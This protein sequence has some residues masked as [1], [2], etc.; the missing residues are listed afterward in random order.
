[1]TA[2]KFLKWEGRQKSSTIKISKP[3]TWDWGR[4][5]GLSTSPSYIYTPLFTLTKKEKACSEAYVAEFTI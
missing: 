1:M 5:I 3:G 2:T 4:S